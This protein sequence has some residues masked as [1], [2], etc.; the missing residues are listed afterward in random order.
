M[1]GIDQADDEDVGVRQPVLN[2]DGVGRSVAG[3]VDVRCRTRSA[4][5]RCRHGPCVEMAK[6][7]S[8]HPSQAGL[9]PIAASSRRVGRRADVLQ[10][11]GLLVARVDAA[12]R[13]RAAAAGSAPLVACSSNPAHERLGSPCGRC[14]G[15]TPVPLSGSESRLHR[16]ARHV[17]RRRLRHRRGRPWRGVHRHPQLR[18]LSGAR[19][20]DPSARVGDVVAREPALRRSPPSGRSVFVSCDG[21]IVS[22]SVTVFV[23]PAPTVTD[24]GL[25]EY[26]APGTA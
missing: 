5:P 18:A 20:H 19:E 10:V 7:S 17:E 21:S 15:S 12:G 2:E 23:S 25:T 13:H 11:G 1:F 16:A 9:S 8:A 26:V 3:R 4:T 24:D 6:Y 14:P 22:V